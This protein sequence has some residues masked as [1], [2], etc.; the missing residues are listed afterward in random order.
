MGI[1]LWSEFEF[2][3]ALY[4]V[5]HDFLANVRHEAEYNVRRVNHHPSL[6]LW[7][8]GNELE[9]LELQEVRA[10][11]PAEYDRYLSE[12]EELFLDTLVPVVFGNSRSISYTPSSTS[13]GWL[14]LNFSSPEPITE[15]YNNL[16]NGSVYGE[17]DY[18]NYSAAVLGNDAAYPV[19]RFANEFGFHSSEYLHGDYL[20]YPVSDQ[21]Q[22]PR[23]KNG[24]SRSPPA[25]LHFN[26]S[27][28]VL[29]NQHYP[30]GNLNV[31]DH[32]NSLR[33]MGEMTNAVAQW[34]PLPDKTDPGANFSAWCHATQ[35][36]QADLYASEIAFYRRG[37][38]L[39]TASWG[40]LYW[41]LN[42]I[43]AAPTWAGVERDGRWKVVHYAAKDIYE[44]VIIAPY[45]D[46]ATGNLSVWVTVGSVE[47]DR[48]HGHADV[49]RL[50]RPAA[51]RP[52]HHGQADPGTWRSAPSI[53]RR[54]GR[55]L[56]PPS[57]ATT[58]STIAS[59]GCRCLPGARCPTRRAT[60]R[61]P[62]RT[63]TGSIP[64][65]CGTANLVDPGPDVAIPER[66]PRI[67]GDGPEAGGRGVGCGSTCPTTVTRWCT[68]TGMRF[69]LAVNETAT[70][71]YKVVRD[72]THGKW[73]ASV[74]ATSI[75]NQTLRG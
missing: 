42:E 63:R 35:I 52:Q 38:G 58:A 13:N 34:Y 15:R 40:A 26:S 44:H 59:C 71:G 23:S 41:Q 27:T 7:A 30:P 54:S 5:T 55:R 28:I 45:Y 73:I 46:A 75:W 10:N 49:V 37:S 50:A 25:D 62:L 14:S 36:F 43:W 51:R 9:N 68:S 33:G 11:A 60:T 57:W 65:R 67:R 1:L 53:R 17:T 8:G 48:R 39:P 66:V 6:A 16:T 32:T 69:W 61:R 31:T 12:Y 64:A 70:V 2:G 47:P 20:A 72:G 21:P 29:R 74:R 3:D 18:Y 19:G 24:A 4:P 22:C 56:P